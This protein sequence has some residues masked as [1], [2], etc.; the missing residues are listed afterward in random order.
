MKDVLVI[1]A[2]LEKKKISNGPWSGQKIL[3]VNGGYLSA[4]DRQESN[5]LIHRMHSEWETIEIRKM[6]NLLENP[7]EQS[8]R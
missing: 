5:K 3:K 6:I 2:D 4:V 7:G 1:R 8:L